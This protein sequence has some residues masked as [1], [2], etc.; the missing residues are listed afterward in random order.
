MYVA[1]AITLDRG[2]LIGMSSQAQD[3]QGNKNNNPNE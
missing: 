3:R 1:S 2:T